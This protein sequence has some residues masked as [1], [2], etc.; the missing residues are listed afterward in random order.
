MLLLP[1][2]EDEKVMIFVPSVKVGDKLRAE[3][4]TMGLET[5]FYHSKFG[6]AWERQE[7]AKRFLGQS[8]PLVNQII[9][10]NAF[11]MGLDIPNVRLVVHWQQPASAEDL[12]Q[13]FGR[14]GRDGKP[15][16]SVIF[17]DGAGRSDVSRLRFMAEKAVESAVLDDQQKA[18][19][20]EQRFRQIDRVAAMLRSTSCFRTSIRDYFGDAK[21][22]KRR[23]LGERVLDWVFETRAPIT[24]YL[25]CCDSCDAKLIKR[26]GAL[27]YV[28]STV[29]DGF[30]A[31]SAR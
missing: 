23:S 11:G 24:R 20:L 18:A 14:A 10:T 29:G 15:A 4:S 21:I 27:I 9:C 5:P 19:I 25:V 16:V 6:T 28:G 31:L 7:L 26:H 8:R 1:Q 3:L 17:H 22:G 13:E 30:R 12:L 2:L